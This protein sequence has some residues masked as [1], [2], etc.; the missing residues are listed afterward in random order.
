M[1]VSDRISHLSR[2]ASRYSKSDLA[3]AV[4][5][6]WDLAN[7]INHTDPSNSIEYVQGQLKFYRPHPGSIESL[8]ELLDAASEK[9]LA[10]EE[11]AEDLQRAGRSLE[12]ALDRANDELVELKRAIDDHEADAKERAE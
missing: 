10:A 9:V 12:A 2:Q 6:V 11:V 7:R 3:A 4:R 5:M 8:R 1:N